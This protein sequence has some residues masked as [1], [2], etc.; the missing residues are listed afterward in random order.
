MEL[1]QKQNLK[2]ILLNEK[3]QLGII[4]TLAFTIPFLL[5]QPQLLIGSIINFILIFSISKYGLKKIVPVL[6]LP[7]LAS[8][9]NGVLFGVFTPYIL[10]L[11]P[12]I[13]LSNLILVLTFKYVKMKYLN[14]GI[15][16]LLKACFLFSTTY[17]L[18]QTI[19]IPEIFLTS[20]GLIQLY[21][22]IIGGGLA[23]IFLSKN[24]EKAS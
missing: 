19:H 2:Q 6:F 1:L 3:I 10:Y 15:A 5:K 24:R 22:G 14:V 16:A 7:S 18:F 17:I 4:Y 23:T 21:T 8:F 12:F 9:L 13:I 20:M 11:M